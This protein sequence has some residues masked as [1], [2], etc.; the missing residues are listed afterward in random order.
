MDFN[1]LH[2]FIVTAECEHLTLASEK[3][4]LSQSAL[5]R[6]IQNLEKEL[7]FP[8]FDRDGRNSAQSIR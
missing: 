1:Q 8:L 2:Y 4:A 6:A 7:G 5:S 3:L